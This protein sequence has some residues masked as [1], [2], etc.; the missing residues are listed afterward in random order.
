MSPGPGAG[1]RR[2]GISARS[3]R[4]GLRRGRTWTSA[5]PGPL[6]ADPKGYD[7]GSEFVA[8][9]PVPTGGWDAALSYWQGESLHGRDLMH[10]AD[11][12]KWTALKPA[13]K[14]VTSD[15]DR[16]PW[17]HEGV[18]D[19]TGLRLLWQ[20][21]GDFTREPSRPVRA[22]QPHARDVPGRPDLDLDRR[23]RRQGR[24]GDRGPGANRRPGVALD[25]GGAS[26]FVDE[27]NVRFRRS[28]TSTDTSEWTARILPIPSGPIASPRGCS[29]VA[30]S[31]WSSAIGYV[32]VSAAWDGEQADQATW[33]SHD[34]L[35]WTALAHP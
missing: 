34:G 25:P 11:G 24:R 23:V 17:T 22:G 27:R 12:L 20:G 3:A 26:G 14:A 5:Y 2:A 18:A 29:F 13:P 32:A 1:R 6:P 9:W 8:A 15:S 16:F 33:L 28:W 30:W 4:L 10:S 7:Q 35:T 31:R 19:G 21:W